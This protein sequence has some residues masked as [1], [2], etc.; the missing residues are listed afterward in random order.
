MYVHGGG[1]MAGPLDRSRHVTEALSRASGM[2]ALDEADTF[3]RRY[4]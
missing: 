1:F 2:T 3:L 4:L